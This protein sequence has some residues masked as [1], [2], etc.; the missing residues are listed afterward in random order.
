MTYRKCDGEDKEG[1]SI[2]IMSLFRPVQELFGYPP[3]CSS[4]HN[5]QQN[6]IA[7]RLAEPETNGSSSTTLRTEAVV[8]GVSDQV[9]SKKEE[10]IPQTIIRSRFSNDEPLELSGDVLVCELALDNA[11]A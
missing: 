2:H 5:G 4:I 6:G 10:R 9:E 1:F 8:A 3:H 11:V 7:P